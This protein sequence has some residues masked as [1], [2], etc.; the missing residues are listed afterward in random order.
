MSEALSKNPF[1]VQPDALT[2]PF[3]NAARRGVFQMPCCDDCN[4]FHFYPKP[5]CPFCGSQRLSWQPARAT[6]RLVA[7]THVHRAL[8]PYFDSRLPLALAIALM[9]DGP[10]FFAKVEPREPGA[11]VGDRITVAFS[12]EGGEWPTPV[13]K[14]REPI[15]A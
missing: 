4:R 2:L 13:F 12:D 8:A 9:D 6:G 5:L 10:A 1:A 11:A 7:V 15:P 14:P 3:W